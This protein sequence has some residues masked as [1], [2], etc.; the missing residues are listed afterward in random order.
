MKK[1]T[2]DIAKALTTKRPKRRDPIPNADLLKTGS[3]VLDLAISGRRAGGIP[4]G[5][6]VW[7]VGD[8]SSGKTFLMLTCLAEASINKGFDNLMHDPGSHGYSYR[9]IF[10]MLFEN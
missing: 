4:K 9:N 7:M 8:S 10:I 3:T 1:S 5:K 6:Y 2:K